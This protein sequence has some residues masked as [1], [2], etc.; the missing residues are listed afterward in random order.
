VTTSPARILVIFARLGCLSF[1]GPVAHLA[2]FRDE[3]VARRGWLDEET[4]GE[5]VALT[6][7]LPG[8]SSSQTGMLVGWLRAGPLGALAAWIGFTAPSA[9]AMAAIA[10]AGP[11]LLPAGPIHALLLVATAVVATAVVTMRTTL[12]P[13][14]TRLAFALATFAL[15]LTLQEP[16]IGPLTIAAGAIA[17]SLLLR[18]RIA[19]GAPK[20]DLPVSPRAGIAVML[21]FVVALFGLD[22]AARATHAPAWMLADTLFRVGSLVFGGGHVVLPLL[23]SQ[24]S[25]SGMLSNDALLTGYAAGQA[26]PGPLFTISS[27]VGASAFGGMLG[28]RGALLGTVAIFAPSFFLLAGA[29]V[30][31]IATAAIHSWIDGVIATVAFVALYFGR[32][33]AWPLVLVAATAG[34]LFR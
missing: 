2:Y 1:G 16:A 6:Q 11:R 24:L 25:A 8:P 15:V 7:L 14:A 20:L 19:A 12:A 22:I 32:A 21:A 3:F 23:Q 18:E 29:L 34:F 31:P 27:F 13:D 10:M 5:C 17:G 28:W 26:M 4:F 33:P 30:T 9:V